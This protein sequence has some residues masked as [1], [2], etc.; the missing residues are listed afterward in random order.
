M[1]ERAFGKPT[2]PMANDPENPLN[3]PAETPTVEALAQLTKDERANI[4][5]ILRR[6]AER[7]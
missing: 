3:P 2:Q 6:A 4:R 5:D 7:S 1:L